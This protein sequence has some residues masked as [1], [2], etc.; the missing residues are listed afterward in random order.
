MNQLDFF[1]VILL[2]VV[3]SVI[4]GL[5]IVNVIDNKL[6]KIE[7]N[8]P[9]VTIKVIQ[10]GDGTYTTEHEK[11]LI[12]KPKVINIKDLDKEIEGFANNLEIN[13]TQDLK[14]I[15]AQDSLKN[16]NYIAKDKIIKSS[17]GKISKIGSHNKTDE[18][19][20][21]PNN[22]EVYESD[23]IFF[24]QE[25]DLRGI[26]P[27][28]GC[29]LGRKKN[30]YVQCNNESINKKYSTGFKPLKPFMI[31][32]Q[33]HD[34]FDP[35]NYYKK[36]YK[37]IKTYMGDPKMKGANY[38]EYSNYIRPEQVDI[39]L[40]PGLLKGYRIGDFGKQ[41]IPV[42]ENYAFLDSPAIE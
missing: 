25:E 19:I 24:S 39:K 22:E 42:A 10:N 17:D 8:L 38:G 2:I 21:Q 18:V 27:S 3:V 6:G 29:K 30:K 33:A 31:Q 5:N 4:I 23:P 7:I 9:P 32:A 12:D 34:T 13:P 36:H 20:I 40:V 1:F 11:T 15:P 28:G 41:N 16:P 14:K 26:C 35:A 37:P